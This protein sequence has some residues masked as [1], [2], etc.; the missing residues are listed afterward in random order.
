MWSSQDDVPK[1]LVVLDF[2]WVGNSNYPSTTQITQIAAQNVHTDDSFNCYCRPLASASTVAEHQSKVGKPSTGQAVVPTEKG[3][4]LFFDWL[5]RQRVDDDTSV[6]V[7]AH[8]G[9]RFDAPVLIANANRHSVPIPSN[10]IVLDSL[11][12]LRYYMK[13]RY[14]VQKF[15]IDSLCKYLEVPIDEDKRHD[16]MYDVELLM[17]ILQ[18]MQMKWSTPYISGLPHPLTYSPMLCH[19][20][21]ITICK[22][23]RTFSLAQLCDQILAEHGDLKYE[24]ALA[25]LSSLDL[26]TCLPAVNLE[27][28]ARNIAETAF[29]YLNYLE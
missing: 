25:Y 20:I 19:G 2:E 14:T 1:S 28:I 8:N 7:I 3:L 5:T 17:K 23:L 18:E 9:I 11:F 24:S 16:A 12:H 27:L 22:H 21:G 4:R 6:S 10:I 15:D 13:H 29:R 26:H